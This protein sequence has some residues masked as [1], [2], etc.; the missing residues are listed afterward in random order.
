MVDSQFC[1]WIL[2]CKEV[3]ATIN[4]LGKDLQDIDNTTSLFQT[5]TTLKDLDTGS[6]MKCSLYK[7][8]IFLLLLTI[9]AIVITSVKFTDNTLINR[10]HNDISGQH[11]F[12]IHETYKKRNQFQFLSEK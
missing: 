11:R 3:T 8:F 5:V 10:T 4:K 7:I 2:N 6:I 9:I 12:Y 1:R